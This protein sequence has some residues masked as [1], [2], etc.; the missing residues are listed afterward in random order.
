MDE[1]V[2]RL[3]KALSS[4]TRMKII[5]CIMD[6]M[7]H[8]D[9]IAKHLGLKRQSVDKHL[10]LLYELRLLDRSAIFPPGGR[11][12]IVYSMSEAGKG[13]LSDVEEVGKRY[14]ERLNTMYRS[15]KR[16]LDMALAEGEISEDV[17]LKN[18]SSLKEKYNIR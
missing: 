14:G 12:R 5:S 11:P 2:F 9:D 18:I 8:P 17:Y 6:G 10:L 4:D 1:T 7:D 16:V 15:E 3:I 13:L